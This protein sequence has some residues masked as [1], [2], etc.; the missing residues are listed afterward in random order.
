VGRL[1]SDKSFCPFYYEKGFA[2]IISGEEEA[3]YGWITVNFLKGTFS[4]LQRQTSYGA[5][6]VGGAST[7]NTFKVAYMNS[8]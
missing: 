4:A 3:L 6:D 7:Q 8:F 2:K 5:L 1:F